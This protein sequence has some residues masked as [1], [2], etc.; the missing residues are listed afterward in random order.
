M[1]IEKIMIKEGWT[2][3]SKINAGKEYITFHKN[4]LVIDLDDINEETKT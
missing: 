2:K 3:T 4:G 1:N